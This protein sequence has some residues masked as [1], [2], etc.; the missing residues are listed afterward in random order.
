LSLFDMHLVRILGAD[1]NL[2]VE[3]APTLHLARGG[4]LVASP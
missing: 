2:S 3:A 1:Q 4:N